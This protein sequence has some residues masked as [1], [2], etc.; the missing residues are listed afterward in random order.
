MNLVCRFD[1]IDEFLPTAG[2]AHFGVDVPHV[3]L[4][5]AFGDEQLVAYIGDAAAAQQQLDDFR[6]ARRQVVE[7]CGLGD[8]VGRGVAVVFGDLFFA[9]SLWRGG[10][11]PPQTFPQTTRGVF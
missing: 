3:S 4:G 1:A 9:L 2:D 5:G 8:A 10:G 11:F 7:D 6:F